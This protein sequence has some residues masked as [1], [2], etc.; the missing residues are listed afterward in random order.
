MTNQID[1]PAKFSCHAQA[2]EINEFYAVNAPF[3]T[4]VL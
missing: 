2:D 3:P 4:E 1:R